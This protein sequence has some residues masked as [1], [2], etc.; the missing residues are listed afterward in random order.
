[1]SGSESEGAKGCLPCLV[2]QVLLFVLFVGYGLR[3]YRRR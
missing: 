1:M 3:R 2:S